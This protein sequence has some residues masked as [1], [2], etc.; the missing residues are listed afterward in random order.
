MFQLLAYELIMSEKK[1]GFTE[2]PDQEYIMDLLI[3]SIN[4]ATT[5]LS[6][7]RET[8][9][10]GFDTGTEVGKILVLREQI[11]KNLFFF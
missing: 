9:I 6:S 2:M 1:R 8:L 10:Q 3:K 4:N 7:D 5:A 11:I